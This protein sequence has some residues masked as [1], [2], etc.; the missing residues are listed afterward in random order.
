MGDVLFAD[1]AGT[2]AAVAATSGRRSKVG[3]LAAALRALAE[4]GDPLEIEAG[5]AYLAGEMRQRQIGVGWASL[6]SLPPAAEVPTMG[7]REVDRR[8]AELAT[9]SG[10][11]SQARRRELVGALFGALT[12]DEI[13][14]SAEF[15]SF[16]TND[17]TQTALGMSRDDSGSFLP[18]YA[19]HEIITKNPFATIDQS[20]V[21]QLVDVA[22]TKGRSTRPDIKLG[23]CGEHGGD[24]ASI[25]FFEQVKLDYV[26]CS[27]FRVPVARLAAAQAALS[28][29]AAD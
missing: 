14:Q 2:S 27:P 15:F 10:T 4:G 9:V 25:R 16:G 23:I 11:G 8:L 5:A 20:G 28:S 13:A 22:V 1:L 19:E 3:L 12:A 26:S 18:T 29:K 6:R 17:L 7:V 21:G 24:P